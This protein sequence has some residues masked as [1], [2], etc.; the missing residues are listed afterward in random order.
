M[1]GPPTETGTNVYVFTV[2]AYDGS[3][4][5]TFEEMVTV[6][7]V[8]EPPTITTTSSSATGLRQA[9]NRTTRLYTYRA[10]DPEDSTITWSVGGTD[11]RF[12]TIDERGQF[13]FR[14]TNPPDYE[15]PGDSGGD[16]VY[17][18][19][20]QARDDGFITGTLDLV[21]AVTDV[22][23]GAGDIGAAEPHVHR[24]TR[25]RTGYW[26]PTTPPTPRTRLR[27]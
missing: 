5:G 20:V 21:V 25:P 19:T 16:N 1:S 18:V 24:E 13:S 7:P 27:S 12:F 26:P 11:G 3:V 9:E 8:N 10:T 23:R 4:Y 22:K 6:T 15:I 14:E 17:N 2:R